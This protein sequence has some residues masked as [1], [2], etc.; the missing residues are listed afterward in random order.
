MIVSMLNGHA[1]PVDALGVLDPGGCCDLERCAPGGIRSRVALQL[2]QQRDRW[3]SPGRSGGRRPDRAAVRCRRARRPRR[4]RRPPRTAPPAGRIVVAAIS[5]LRVGC[6]AA[7][8]A[9]GAASS[10][11]TRWLTR[12]RSTPPAMQTASVHSSSW[13]KT[14]KPSTIRTA[15]TQMVLRWSRRTRPTEASHRGRRGPCVTARFLGHRAGLGVSGRSGHPGASVSQRRRTRS[16]KPT[17]PDDAHGDADED[18]DR[19]G[20]CL[21]RRR[22]ARRPCHRPRRRRGARRGREV[23]TSQGVLGGLIAHVAGPF[24]RWLRW[25][26]AGLPNAQAAG[27]RQPRTRRRPRETTTALGAKNPPC[28]PPS[29]RPSSW[30]SSW[31]SSSLAASSDRRRAAV[32]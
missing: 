23:A 10:S 19:R 26:V 9:A 15:A 5:C 28:D 20:A 30:C 32:L 31:G 21:R 7:G 13:P 8:D 24:L 2:L 14:Q 16:Q 18:A 27:P 22:R 1:E 4:R 11:V 25:G 17:P 12:P 3:S 29:A 6:V